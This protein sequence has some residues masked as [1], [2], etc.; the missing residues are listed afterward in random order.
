MQVLAHTRSILYRKLGRTPPKPGPAREA[1]P[2][3]RT[4]AAQYSQRLIVIVKHWYD[5]VET[6][7]RRELGARTDASFEEQLAAAFDA[8]VKASGVDAFLE[9][10][11]RAIANKQAS[12]LKRVTKLPPSRMATQTLIEQYRQENARLIAGLQESQVQRVTDVLR[13]AQSTGDR[14]EDVAPGIKHA[15]GVGIDRARLIARDQTNKF[16]GAM[17]RITQTSAGVDEYTWSTTKA[18]S[19][20]GYPGG[21][22]TRTGGASHYA[23]EGTRHKWSDPPVIPG[24]TDRAHPG[25]QINC[26]CVAIPVIPAFE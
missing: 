17:Q 7:G 6:I 20:R 1:P 4:E 18:A 16:N 2:R 24:T 14:W 15:A 9:R 13:R 3:P 12:Y 22:N 23:L 11:A 21:P 5:H 10:K 26:E 25:E 8:L 19:V